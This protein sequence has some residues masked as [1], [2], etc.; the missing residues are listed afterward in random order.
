M[1]SNCMLL[2]VVHGNRE[3][4][5]GDH[6]TL[7]EMKERKR[8]LGYSNETLA[9][10]SGVPIGTVQKV[11]AGLTRSPRQKTIEALTKVLASADNRSA[12]AWKR[13]SET[14][15][16]YPRYD[17]SA[18]WGFIAEP[19]PAYEVEDREYTIE[20]IRALPEGIRA[21][22]I[23]G[24]IYYMATPLRTHQKI[25]GE[26]HFSIMNHIR[27]KGGSCEV[28]TAPFGVYLFGDEGTYL[29]PDLTV[30]CD[31]D[32]LDEEGCH[33]APDWVVEVNSPSTRKRDNTIK[34][35]KYRTAGVREYW[36]IHPEKRVTMVYIF[37]KEAEDMIVYSFDDGVASY[38]F[39]DLKI[40]LSDTL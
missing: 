30:I 19:A 9:E 35:F 26:M 36:I 8:I 33:G 31:K 7:E 4:L 3:K 38:I 25:V 16:F 34:L 28:Y 13:V 20:D 11:M 1:N 23:D 21:E 10:K 39:P 6:M 22:L 27:S 40:R 18:P 5:R 12:N 14:G 15:E 24:K 37:E 17:P 32:K 2:V 29:E